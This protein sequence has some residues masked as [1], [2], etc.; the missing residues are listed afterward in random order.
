MFVT[1]LWRLAGSPAGGECSF[2]DYVPN[3]YYSEALAWAANNSIVSGYGNGIFGVNDEV[4]REQLCVIIVNY[5]K[6]IGFDLSNIAEG[7]P[8]SDDENISSWAKQS[9][10][11]CRSLGL[12]KGKE[13]NM[14]DPKATSTRAECST[15]FLRLI[16]YILQNIKIN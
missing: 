1:V 7:L 5:L 14:F 15:V 3:A 2:E 13:G 8:F 16:K 12:I 6:Y 11:I 10:N 4:S 9:V